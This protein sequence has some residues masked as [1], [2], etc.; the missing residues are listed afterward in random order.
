MASIVRTNLKEVV[1]HFK[2]LED[3]RS[4]VN[5]LHPLTSVIVIAI[6]AVLAG[7]DG[8]TAI[9]RWAR[10]ELCAIAGRYSTVQPGT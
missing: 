2:E 1:Q 6:M 5:R 10:T 4:A 7:A 8:P 9:P 3:P